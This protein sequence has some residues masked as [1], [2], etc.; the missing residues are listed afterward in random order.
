VNNVSSREPMTLTINDPDLV[1]AF[2]KIW[3][4]ESDFKAPS[5]PLSLNETA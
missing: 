5:I 2:L 1:Q 4:V 3:W